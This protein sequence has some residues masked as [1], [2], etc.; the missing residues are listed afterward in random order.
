MPRNWPSVIAFPAQF[1]MLFEKR[2]AFFGICRRARLSAAWPAE[3]RRPEQ[4]E[5]QATEELPAREHHSRNRSAHRT[6][7]NVRQPAVVTRPKSPLWMF[8]PGLLKF[9]RLNALNISQRN[10]T[11]G[12]FR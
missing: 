1:Q 9:T 11:R 3:F 7:W 2:V 12:I 4:T 6:T 5:R 8:V 10:C